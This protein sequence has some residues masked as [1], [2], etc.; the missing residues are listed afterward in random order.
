M[1]MKRI[2]K[3]LAVFLATVMLI[4][5]LAGCSSKKENTSTTAGKT[6]EKP[7]EVVMEIVTMGQEM[8]SIPAI[9]EAINKISLKEINATV[10]LMNIGI[11]EH[12][13][14]TSLL[15][16]SGTKVD[17]LL[18]GTTT[19]VA[20]LAADGILNPID[21]LLKTRGKDILA[22]M[23]KIKGAGVVN[24]KTYAIS[25]DAYPAQGGA[26]VFNKEVAD[27]NGIVIPQKPTYADLE[28]AFQTIKEK[29]KGM[30]GVG[31]STGQLSGAEN[32]YAMDQ[33][34]DSAK[35]T[36]GV[37]MN[38]TENTQIVNLYATKEYKEY[39]TKVKEWKDK[40]YIMPDGMT[41]GI[42]GN[43]MLK[44]KTAFMLG[45]GYDMSQEQV[46]NRN[47]GFPVTLVEAIDPVYSTRSVQ[48]VMWGIP[49]TSKN[50]EK[51]MEFLNLMYKNAEI[52]NLLCNG[53][54]GKEYKKVSENI[55]T[56]ADGVDP[57][58][59]GY[60]R[61]FSRFGDTMKVKQWQPATEDF[62]KNVKAFNDRAKNTKS[63]GYIFDPSSV[64]TELTAISNVIDKHRPALECGVVDVET[65]LNAFLKDLD[66]AGMQKV[67]QENQ[68]QFNKWLA[69][70]K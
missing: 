54:E 43:D 33:L 13:Q 17:L 20:S 53:I 50:P 42:N 67:I 46:W 8:K 30:Y 64:K 6:D 18:V 51:A 65:A 36:K 38:P 63:L 66:A 41:S 47:M 37:I 39:V 23:D 19:N 5:S 21:D 60:T 61:L 68:S 4:S 24:G 15:T 28:K 58:N 27:R 44:A 22:L 70:K 49:V 45:T 2:T 48:E 69:S 55:I 31:I 52:A 3:R 1:A 14:K 57:K 29:E 9:E 7:Y 26:F 12:A 40:G 35:M 62:Y 59:I 25:A 10:K 16:A 11:P 32:F 56:Y 34:G